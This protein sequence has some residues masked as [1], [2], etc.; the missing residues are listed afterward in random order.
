[1]SLR[2]RSFPQ[3]AL[4][5]VSSLSAELG[6]CDI[7]VSDGRVGSQ[8]SLLCRRIALLTAAVRRMGKGEKFFHVIC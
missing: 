5:K 8:V 3:S 4:F 2:D 7:L 6:W 1:M